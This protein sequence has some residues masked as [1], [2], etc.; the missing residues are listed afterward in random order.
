MRRPLVRI[1]SLSLRLGPGKLALDQQRRLTL[2]PREFAF[3]TGHHVR[4]ILDHP[5]Q[6]GD[7]FFQPGQ[8][9]ILVHAP[10]KPR[11]G[12]K[13]K[14]RPRLPSGCARDKATPDA[15]G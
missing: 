8:M 15:S 9:R 6:M 14:P 7:L 10:H 11:P 3:L 13:G 2:Q 12:G 1:G 5:G 4:K